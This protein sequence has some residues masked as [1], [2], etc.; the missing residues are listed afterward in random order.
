MSVLEV[1]TAPDKRLSEKASPV[2]SVDSEIRKLMNDMIQTVYADAAVGLAATQVG[3]MKRVI[4]L[5]L[6]DDDETD[7]SKDF[8]PIYAANPEIVA[9]SE[10]MIEAKEGCM[11]IPGQRVNVS[12]PERIKVKF[13]DYNN[14]PQEI[15]T[16]GWLARVFQHEIDHL[17]G[18]LMIDYLSKLKKDTVIRKLTKIKRLS[19]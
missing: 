17:D 19:A 1:L 9:V 5:D 13:L 11:S 12:R 6:K 8:Y 4:V 18:K 15:E 2:S 10:E 7:R 14:K 16:G 3:V